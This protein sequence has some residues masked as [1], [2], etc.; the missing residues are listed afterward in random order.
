[1]SKE[2]TIGFMVA[3]FAGVILM[4]A[5]FVFY[6]TSGPTTVL[7]S[8]NGGSVSIE[9]GETLQVSLSGNPTTGYTW[10]ITDLDTDILVQVGEPAFD[11]DTNLLGSPGAITTDFEG[12]T[13]GT[14]QLVMEYRSVAGGDAVNIFTIS[15]TVK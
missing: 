8:D 14:T 11:P 4:I 3:M 12:T 2:G 13:A 9:T 5:L 1:M 7:E 15:V 6:S 10:F